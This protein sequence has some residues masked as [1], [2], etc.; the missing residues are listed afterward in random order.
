MASGK[1]QVIDGKLVVVGGKV[2][3]C[4]EDCFT[5]NCDAGDCVHFSDFTPDCIEA[6][7]SGFDDNGLS[8][9]CHDGS[10]YHGWDGCGTWDWGDD[11]FVDSCKWVI[12][13]QCAGPYQCFG[14]VGVGDDLLE[15]HLFGGCLGRRF[16]IRVPDWDA[17]AFSYL[18]AASESQY[19]SNFTGVSLSK[20]PGAP[21]YAP[22][23]VVLNGAHGE[24]VSYLGPTTF[25]GQC[26]GCG[27]V[28]EQYQV[29][30]SGFPD[31]HAFGDFCGC[32]GSPTVD[33]VYALS[34]GDMCAG[35]ND[36]YYYWS[37]DN[38]YIVLSFS[39]TSPRYIV[40]TIGDKCL[41]G[42]NIATS[43]WRASSVNKWNC[44]GIANQSLAYV[45][46]NN[47]PGSAAGSVVVDSL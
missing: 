2:S 31:T 27:A 36:W 15:V 18:G 47:W 26:E 4:D 22:D 5:E 12:P 44:T 19:A 32:G 30:L 45:G 35:A 10:Y 41:G 8:C 25:L 6:V 3:T 29:T 34:I 21:G 23:T 9:S 28:S 17:S 24:A 40:L 33:G 46:N 1:I 16:G 20:R 37:Y 13:Q 38:C 11:V 43:S 7:F 14:D 39:G 42:A